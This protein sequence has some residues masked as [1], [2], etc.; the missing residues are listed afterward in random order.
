MK[1]IIQIPCYNEEQTLGTTLSALPRQ[2]L[3][4]DTVEWLIVDDG[5]SDGTVEVALAH[6]VDHVIR[7]PRNQG[8][9]RAFMAGMD[10]SLKAGADII[11]NT[12]ADNQ[13]CAD[14]IPKLIEPILAGHAEIVVGARPITEIEHFSFVKKQ[15]QKL[16]SAVVRI[17]SNTDIPDAPSGFRAMSRVAAMQLNVFNEYTYTL[18][19]IIQAGQKG[20]AI[21][22]VPIRTN[23]DLRP[24]RLVKSIPRYVLR[25]IVTI[26]RIFMTYKPFRFFAVPGTIS[27]LCGFLLGL[28][29]LYYFMTIGGVGHVQS[30]ILAA[31]LMGNGFFLLVVGLLAD[32]AAVNRKLLEKMIV[33]LKLL[34]KL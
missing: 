20:M 24:S 1:L 13:Y 27:F 26:L 33:E 15:L 14:D 5:S 12:D 7:L 11:V 16:G 2:I 34:N 4:I 22:S 23:E 6:G 32:L 29:F 19:T 21:T 9:A 28:R 17:A 18:E 31:L 25:S 10:A 3:G 30:L 8:L